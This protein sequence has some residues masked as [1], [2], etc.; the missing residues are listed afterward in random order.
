M[1]GSNCKAV[2]VMTQCAQA[3][4]YCAQW[5]HGHSP[6]FPYSKRV[7]SPTAA[8]PIWWTSQRG[9]SLQRG[10]WKLQIVSIHFTRDPNRFCAAVVPIFLCAGI[11]SLQGHRQWES[12]HTPY[13]P[14]QLCY[15][16]LVCANDHGLN[17]QLYVYKSLSQ[18]NKSNYLNTNENKF[19]LQQELLGQLSTVMR[20]NGIITAIVFIIRPAQT[21][22]TLDRGIGL[23]YYK[24]PNLK[25]IFWSTT[26]YGLGRPRQLVRLQFSLISLV[27]PAKTQEYIFG[28]HFLLFGK[29]GKSLATFIKGLTL[30]IFV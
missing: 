3:S 16:G 15:R 29:R 18:T 26:L 10:K 20:N 2:Q 13:R 25:H 14:L 5:D 23:F 9:R 1:E 21:T 28:V 24:Q 11:S 27:S 7:G 6:N 4:Q 12:R 19:T 22:H 8:L 17:V 30:Q